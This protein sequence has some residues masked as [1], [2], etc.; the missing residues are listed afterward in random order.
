MNLMQIKEIYSK[1]E[2]ALGE[3]NR[4]EK[5]NF[6]KLVYGELKDEYEVD[7]KSR[8]M[9]YAKK[10]SKENILEPYYYFLADKEELDLFE[11]L[12]FKFLSQEAEK[13]NL[14][15]QPK[16]KEIKN[17]EPT[18]ENLKTTNFNEQVQL[19]LEINQNQNLVKNQI[20]ESKAKPNLESKAKCTNLDKSNNNIYMLVK[21]INKIGSIYQNLNEESKPNFEK[22]LLKNLTINKCNVYS[23]QAKDITNIKSYIENQNQFILNISSRFDI[24]DIDNIIKAMQKTKDELKIA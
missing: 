22:K 6:L 1:V 23:R 14:H 18:I 2:V 24:E 9:H 21:I 20:Q 10:D 15:Q 12:C 8:A 17:Q 13:E 5:T 7:L 19:K 16:S 3:A 11:V 4:F